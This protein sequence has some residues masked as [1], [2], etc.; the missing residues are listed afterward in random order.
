M[1]MMQRCLLHLRLQQMESER[2]R[3]YQ[4]SGC[5]KS[6]GQMIWLY[7]PKTM[8]NRICRPKAQQEADRPGEQSLLVVS[9]CNGKLILDLQM[10][11]LHLSHHVHCNEHVDH[12]FE[13]PKARKK[14]NRATRAH[15]QGQHWWWSVL[16]QPHPKKREPLWGR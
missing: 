10:Q 1:M 8:A 14:P 13:C 2:E 11:G 3:Q 16:T 6:E 5:C 4:V 7:R 12:N 9:P 15:Q